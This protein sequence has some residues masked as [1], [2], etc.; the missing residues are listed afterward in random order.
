MAES[1]LMLAMTE[2][3]SQPVELSIF[4]EREGF[5]SVFFGGHTHLLYPAH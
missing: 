4:A 3:T 5:E 1:G 2:H